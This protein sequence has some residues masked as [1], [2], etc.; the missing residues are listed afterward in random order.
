MSDTDKVHRPEC[1]DTE[2]LGCIEI[3]Q[4][5]FSNELNIWDSWDDEGGSIPPENE[6]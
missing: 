4:T 6:D 2:C 1:D 3:D 5:K